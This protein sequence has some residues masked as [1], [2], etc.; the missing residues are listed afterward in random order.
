MKPEAFL[1]I[2]HTAARTGAPIELLR[3][4][5]W[6]RKNTPNR[7][8][9]ILQHGGEMEADFRALGTTRVWK[10]APRKANR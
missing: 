5:G 6:L 7:I 4:L 1:F 9:I 8:L 10:R 3:F 2:S